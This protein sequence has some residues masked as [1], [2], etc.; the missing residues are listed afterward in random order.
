MAEQQ[1][2]SASRFEI[3][4]DRAWQERFWTAQRIAWVVMAL[5]ILAALVGLTGKG[6]PLASA[7]AQTP[8]GSIEYPRIARWQSDE[9]L[10]VKLPPGASGEVELE[11]SSAFIETFAVQTIKPEPSGAVA[12][13]TGHRFT[14][15]VD[16][17]GSKVIQFQ[18]QAA[19][20]VLFQPVRASI[21]GSRPAE[22]TVTVLP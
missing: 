9:L 21:E 22:M 16:G 4:E 15:D 19:N 17:G 7:T 5:F 20:P 8:G 6:G 11:L 18:L 12:T 2:T 13:G 3:E 1:S 10:T 14:F